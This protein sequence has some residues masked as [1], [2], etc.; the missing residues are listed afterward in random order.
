MNIGGVISAA[1]AAGCL[2]KEVYHDEFAVETKDDESPLT[3]ADKASHQ[4]IFTELQ[5]LYPAIP[6]LS[7]ESVTKPWDIRRSWNEYW[8]IDPLDGTKEFIKRNGEFTVNISLIRDGVSV[9]GVVYA[10]VLDTLWYA[11]QGK[12]AFKKVG[13][14]PAE[15]IFASSMALGDTG[16]RVVGS[17]S[18]QNNSIQQFLAHFDSPELVPMGSSL[19]LC[20]VADG[21]ADIYPRLGLTSEW[22]TAAAQCVVEEAGGYILEGSGEALSYNQKE[23]I[24][25]PYFCVVGQCGAAQRSIIMQWFNDACSVNK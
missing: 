5:R 17:R 6:V 21:G 7:E 8:L 19:K 15:Q 10:P 18:H 13:D 23:S 9:L 25:N 12:G 1:Y 4:Y 22:D 16:V 24:L 11:E 2:I 3:V 14:A 20:A